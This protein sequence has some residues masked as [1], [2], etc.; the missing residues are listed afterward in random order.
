MRGKVGAFKLPS[1]PATRGHWFFLCLGI[2]LGPILIGTL[3]VSPADAQTAKE[4]KVITRIAPE[5][6]ET[7]KQL[8]IGG[9]VRIQ[10]LV[11]PNGTVE[12]T[13]L[14]GG[15]PILGQAAMKAVKQWKYSN[16]DSREELEVKV[17]FY[18]H[19]D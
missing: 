15:N 7:L 6:P 13:R 12:S 4:R 1:V 9:V 18:P 19:L 11:A 3:L 16:A 8:H 17:E 2:F 10:A 14:L 5:Y